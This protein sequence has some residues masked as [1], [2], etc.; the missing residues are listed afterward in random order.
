MGPVLGVNLAHARVVG[1]NSSS[2]PRLAF[3]ENKRIFFFLEKGLI[4]LNLVKIT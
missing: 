1:V 4:Y 3:R 2:A